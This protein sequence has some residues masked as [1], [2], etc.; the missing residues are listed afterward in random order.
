[1]KNLKNINQ[2]LFFIVIVAALLY[3]GSNF[4]IPFVFGI[5][6]ATLLTPLSNLIERLWDKRVISSFLGTLV[7]LVVVGALLFVFVHQIR[8]FVSDLSAINDEVQTLIKSLQNKITETTSLSLEEQMNIWHSRSEGFVSSLESGLTSFLEN[9]LNTTAGFF[10]VLVYVFLLLYYRNKIFESILMYVKKKNKE[11][12]KEVLKGISHVV[13]HYLWGR[14]KVMSILAVMYYITFL[15]FD[16]PYALMLT[17]FGALVT[18]IPYLGPFIS[19]VIPI[20][21]SFIYLD[22]VQMALLFSVIIVIEQLIESY[23]LEPL[24]IGHEVKMNPLIVIIAIV[25]GSAI[26][27]L[28]GMI[29]FVPIFAMIGIISNHT[30]ELRPVGYLFGNSKKSV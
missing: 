23:V 5:F 11:E 4:L 6:F 27:G 2:I 3:F 15:I 8:L 19:G 18:I 9:T 20:L 29:L 7:V 28:A 17:I 16:I 26:W 25:L 30:A 10:L 21:F 14:I 12:A 13:Y 1:M 22:N 24:I